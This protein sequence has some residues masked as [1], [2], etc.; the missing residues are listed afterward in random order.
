MLM[1][2]TSTPPWQRNEETATK[3][4]LM[5][6]SRSSCSRKKNRKIVRFFSP[7]CTPRLVRELG[8]PNSL[9]PKQNCL[10][11]SLVSERRLDRSGYQS[12]LKFHPKTSDRARQNTSYLFIHRCIDLGY[13]N[14]KPIP[15]KKRLLQYETTTTFCWRTRHERSRLT[16]GMFDVA[17]RCIAYIHQFQS[18]ID[19][20]LLN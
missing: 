11:G 4:K 14:I 2:M 17:K 9:L 15:A 10:I 12:N 20:D 1:T 5:P 19:K 6:R 7:S 18:I 16:A 13:A 8:S 3:T